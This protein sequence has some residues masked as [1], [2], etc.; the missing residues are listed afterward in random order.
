MIKYP[1]DTTRLRDT[2]KVFIIALLVIAAGAWHPLFGQSGSK[3]RALFFEDT[4]ILNVTITTDMGKLLR[5][6][7]SGY[8]F[9]GT[10]ATVLPDGTVVHDTVQLNIRGHFRKDYCYIPP[11]SVNF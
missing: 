8:Q 4:A 11:V 10:F 9:P 3:T 5:Q 1:F 2:I 7:K 6:K